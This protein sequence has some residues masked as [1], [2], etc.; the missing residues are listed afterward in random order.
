MRYLALPLIL[1]ALFSI[2]GGGVQRE[3]ISLLVKEIDKGPNS[4]PQEIFRL[5]MDAKSPAIPY[6]KEMLISSDK[7]KRTLASQALIY[8]GGDD[9][10]SA[11]AEAYR[12]GIDEF[13]T[14]LCYVVTSRGSERDISYLID[15]LRHKESQTRTAAALSLGLLRSAKAVPYLEL[16]G[17]SDALDALRWIRSVPVS[18]NDKDTNAIAPVESKII[19]SLL[20]TGIPKIAQTSKLIDRKRNGIW[21][22][23]PN[24]WEFQRIRVPKAA[25][26]EIS[27]DITLGS[28][29]S[30]ALVST[31]IYL[32]YQIAYG[33]EYI[34][35]KLDSIWSVR[36][37]RYIWIV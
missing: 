28:D 26:P 11:I 32:G 23:N 5:S 10:I 25:G 20:K 31:N 7:W 34:L 21:I 29:G 35:D 9:A 30:H 22:R 36:T 12:S 17:S 33:Y 2:L 1:S 3:K 14:A 37:I 16:E 4:S 27:F 8:I 15:S 19:H 24:S 13:S 18:I 6:L